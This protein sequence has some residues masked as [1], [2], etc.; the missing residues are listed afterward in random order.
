MERNYITVMSPYVYRIGQERQQTVNRQWSNASLKSSFAA[1]AAL[2]EI[3]GYLDRFT[4][5]G[6]L[7]K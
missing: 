1:A 2:S 6:E 5:E 7:E 4:V 3:T